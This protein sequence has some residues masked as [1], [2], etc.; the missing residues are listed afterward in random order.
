M[1]LR[2][3]LGTGAGVGEVSGQHPILAFQILDSIDEAGL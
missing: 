2:E 3:L 1:L